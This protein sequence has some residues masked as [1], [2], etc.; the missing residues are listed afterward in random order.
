MASQ[1]FPYLIQIL[2]WYKFLTWYKIKNVSGKDLYQV[3][4]LYQ[5]RI[6]NSKNYW[7][8]KLSS[9]TK[10]KFSLTPLRDQNFEIFYNFIFDHYN[11][12]E[13]CTFCSSNFLPTPPSIFFRKFYLEQ[14]SLKTADL[15]VGRYAR[16]GDKFLMRAGVNF[17]SIRNSIWPRSSSSMDKTCSWK[18]SSF[19]SFELYNFKSCHRQWTLQIV[20]TDT[21][22]G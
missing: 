10:T 5:V 14:K 2:T 7:K 8:P 3:M 13:S 18:A 19:S 12:F 15:R 20:W 6:W 21:M 17:L 11:L 4:I 22:Q 16:R 9:Q 1:V